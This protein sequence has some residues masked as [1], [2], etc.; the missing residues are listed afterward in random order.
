[1]RDPSGG[2]RKLSRGIIVLV[3]WV[4]KSERGVASLYL[5]FGGLGWPLGGP[6]SLV[7]GWG[8]K[9]QRG[10]ARVQEGILGCPSIGVSPYLP[11]GG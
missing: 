8:S 5:P 10:P 6:T 4:S 3:V 11:F 9:Y 2:P 1:M 7:P